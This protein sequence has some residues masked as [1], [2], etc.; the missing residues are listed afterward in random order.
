MAT[1]AQNGCMARLGPGS[2]ELWQGTRFR[3]RP[4]EGGVVRADEVPAS[5]AACHAHRQ[6]SPAISGWPRGLV[7]R[8]T[9]VVGSA[10]AGKSVLL[11]DSGSGK[12]TRPDFLAVL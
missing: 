5:G 2:R 1:L 6:A 4:L 8:L 10:G 9:V 3:T 7:E 11:A 12:T